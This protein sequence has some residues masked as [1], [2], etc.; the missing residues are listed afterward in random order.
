MKS[1]FFTS[2]TTWV[3]P[4]TVFA[5]V[6]RPRNAISQPRNTTPQP[7]D[8]IIQPRE[9]ILQPRNAV[10]QPRSTC[11]LPV[12]LSENAF[13]TRELYATLHYAA[14]VAV[15][16]TQIA[17]PTLA[18]RAAQIGDVGTFMWM[19]VPLFFLSMWMIN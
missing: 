4:S 1:F 13:A 12:V 11:E 18:A 10:I 9:T 5:A 3:T 7:R 6:L 17:D 14:K 15:A 19:F 2:L 8:T 16:V